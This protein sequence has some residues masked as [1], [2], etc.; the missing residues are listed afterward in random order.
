MHILTPFDFVARF[1]T[2]QR[3]AF[4]G[5]GPSLKGEELGAWID[6]HD[7]VVRFNESPAYEHGNDTGV[8]TQILVSNPYPTDR[9]H[10][11]LSDGGALAIITPQTRRPATPDFDTWVGRNPVMFT[12]APDIVQVGNIEH[13]AALT[14]GVY[15][16][17]LLS[18]LLQPS[19]VSV[20]GY[21]LFLADTAHHYWTDTSPPGLHAHDPVVEAS[22]F[23]SICNSMRFPLTVTEE[24]VW[25]SKTVGK[26]L[27]EG[28]S[29]RSLKNERWRDQSRDSTNY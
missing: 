4:V 25:V 17:H 20:T 5:N 8:R 2:G 14:T 9:R 26:P 23:I 21:T 27:K 29:I 16:L 1:A 18:R 7:I 24:I 12:Y 13:T 28:V 22:V 3:V 11:N 19:Q 15:G 6:A 10:P